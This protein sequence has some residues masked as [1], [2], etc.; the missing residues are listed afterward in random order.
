VCLARSADWLDIFVAQV[1]IESQLIE[2]IFFEIVSLFVLFF[3]RLCHLAV[4]HV[5]HKVNQVGQFF[6]VRNF[7][8]ELNNFVTCHFCC[9]E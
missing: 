3:S 8:L 6:V 5:R 2:R 7:S 4:V 9:E 1:K